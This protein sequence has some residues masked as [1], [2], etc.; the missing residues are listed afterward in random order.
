MSL[1]S[2]R[3]APSRDTW[4]ARPPFGGVFAR[5]SFVSEF[6]SF[7]VWRRPTLPRLETQY[8]WRRHTYRP[9]SGWDR[10]FC[11]RY[12]HQTGEETGEFPPR[13]SVLFQVFVYVLLT[14]GTASCLAVSGSDQA[15]RAI[16]TSQLNAL[17]RL[18][19]WPIDVV[20]FHGPQ[21]RP[22]FE[23]GFP[24]RCLQRL[25]CPNIATQHCRWHDNW[26]TSGSFNPVLSY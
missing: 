22:C 19:L 3:A 10:E 12:D 5:S 18:H 9:S 7:Q 8:H 21:G 25:S 26:S 1:T 2:Y 11:A 24:L 17:L 16:S 15:N 14:I 6:V 20:V 23:G 4:F 13:T